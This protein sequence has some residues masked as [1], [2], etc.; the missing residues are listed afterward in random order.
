MAEHA[1]ERRL[2]DGVWQTVDVLENGGGGGGS[3][4]VTDGTTTVDPATT[5]EFP[6]GTVT[7][8]GGG[9]AQVAGGG[10]LPQ[11]VISGGLVICDGI[12]DIQPATGS[13][14]ST[15]SP[16][17]YGNA[18]GIDS[19]RLWLLRSPLTIV[20]F[21]FGIG[22]GAGA[23]G[24]YRLGL[25]LADAQ[26]QPQ[27]LIWDSGEQDA[28]VEGRLD[29]AAALTLAPGLY[30]QAACFDDDAIGNAPQLACQG[31]TGPPWVSIGMTSSDLA[32][33]TLDYPL[34]VTRVRAYGA[35]PDPGLPW[36]TVDRDAN[37]LPT[38]SAPL[39]AVV[40]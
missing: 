31:A 12:A 36:G 40:A 25:Y 28:S 20:R 24:L 19:F 3:I 11:P 13:S 18:S 35:F 4:S 37:S 17:E 2:I 32:N 5:V 33:F 8:A 21:A 22:S 15:A 38:V 39:F 1:I 27:A 34:Q 7:D 16:N 14:F 23:V 29:V 9:V 26:A 10:S 6:S 30:L